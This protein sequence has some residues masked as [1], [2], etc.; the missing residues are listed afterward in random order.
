VTWEVTVLADVGR[1][2][3]CFSA[4]AGQ[5]QRCQPAHIGQP[6]GA[7][8]PGLSLRGAR[9]GGTSGQ[10][11][12][13]GTLVEAIVLPEEFTVSQGE[14]VIRLSPSLAAGMTDGLKY[15]EH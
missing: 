14:L 9:N 11:A 5:L 4:A 12:G 7:G 3:W 10:T 2:D 15:L 8:H 6:G 13:G 1:V